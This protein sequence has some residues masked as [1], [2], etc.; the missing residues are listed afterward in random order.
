MKTDQTFFVFDEA[1]N[2]DAVRRLVKWPGDLIHE[3]FR[4]R[5]LPG[6]RLAAHDRRGPVIRMGALVPG[7]K[8]LCVGSEIDSRDR[9]RL[10]GKRR[11]LVTEPFPVVRLYRLHLGLELRPADPC[12]FFDAPVRIAVA[13]VREHVDIGL[14]RSE[15]QRRTCSQALVIRVRCDHRDPVLFLKNHPYPHLFFLRPFF[16]LA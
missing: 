9:I 14:T 11:I 6:D 16:L 5:T 8:D 7:Q 2:I 12:L 13:P 15:N 10:P 4:L 3:A 1:G